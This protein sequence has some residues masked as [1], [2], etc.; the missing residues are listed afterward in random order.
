MIM[1][2]LLKIMAEHNIAIRRIP[3]KVVA[4]YEMRHHVVGNDIVTRYGRQMT[5]ET[6]VPKNAGKFLVAKTCGTMSTAVF[7]LK[8]MGDTIEEAVNKYLESI[9]T[10]SS[11]GVQPG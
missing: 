1:D 5:Q 7:D 3:D 4:T 6:T 10:K 8:F 2:T 9:R 11:S